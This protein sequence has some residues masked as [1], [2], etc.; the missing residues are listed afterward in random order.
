LR[1]LGN[2]IDFVSIISIRTIFVLTYIR[3]LCFVRRNRW[4]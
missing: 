1:K 3:C 2:L 4:N